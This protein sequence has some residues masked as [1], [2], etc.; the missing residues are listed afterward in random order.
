MSLEMIAFGTCLLC[1]FLLT[2]WNTITRLRDIHEKQVDQEKYF[3]F[4]RDCA[5]SVGERE[6]IR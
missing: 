1:V 6:K 5:R 3:R 2:T 4:L